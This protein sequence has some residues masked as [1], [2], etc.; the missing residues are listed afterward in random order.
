[1]EQWTWA[2]MEKAIDRQQC[3]LSYLGYYPTGYL[4]VHVGAKRREV[5]TNAK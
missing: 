2:S 5:H 1:M 4:G 3:P